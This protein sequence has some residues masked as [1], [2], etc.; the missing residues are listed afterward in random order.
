MISEIRIGVAHTINL[1]NYES[2]RIEAGITIN[3]KEGDDLVAIKAEGQQFLRATTEE[4]YKA[5]RRQKP[6]A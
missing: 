6:T 3:V 1:G 2:L 5:Q 4:T